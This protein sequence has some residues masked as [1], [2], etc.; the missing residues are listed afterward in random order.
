MKI[1]QFL[2]LLSSILTL[3]TCRPKVE[4]ARLHAPPPGRSEIMQGLSFVAPP[5][6]FGDSA[7]IEVQES[8]ADWIAVIPYGFSRP[9]EAKVHFDHE[10][11]W[12]GERPVGTQTTI[13]R[14]HAEGLSVMLKPQV[15]VPRS[16][17]GAI[18]FD[19]EE[20]W[21][22]W[23]N[24]YREYLLPMA[25]LADSMQ[26]KLFCIGT[27]FK[28]SSTQRP[29]F[30]RKLIQDIR[31][32]YSGQLTYAAN[33]DEYTHITFWDQLDYIGIDAYFPLSDQ[34]TPS[35]AELRKAWQEPHRAMLHT[36]HTYQRPY[37]FTEFGY[38]SVDSCASRTWELEDRRRQLN[39]NQQAQAN[40]LEAVF[41]EFWDDT[42]WA[43]G[44]IW[45][46]YPYEGRRTWYRQKDYTPQN[47]LAAKTLK[48]WYE[49]P[50][51]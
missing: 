27:E 31:S 22:A 23:E 41:Q 47:K 13:Q 3:D 42:A 30:W 4:A 6:P 36:A 16:W 43:G 29:H 12:W 39:A 5:Q 19:S 11:Q 15:Y 37:L 28:I 8:G 1:T 38:M 7:M 49:K 25:R 14:A 17:T 24:S 34:A 9:G 33:W 21:T 35:V 40:A 44:F 32:I 26:V 2:L 20:E 46:W 10:R 50:A 45:K 48:K 18:S 51:N